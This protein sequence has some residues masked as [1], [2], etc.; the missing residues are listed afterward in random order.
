MGR[1]GKRRE[2]NG[3]RNVGSKV[4]F[5]LAGGAQFGSYGCA[6]V[7]VDKGNEINLLC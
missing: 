6:R 4:G 7:M 1:E 5:G 3:L 2:G